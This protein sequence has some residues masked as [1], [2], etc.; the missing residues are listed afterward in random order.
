MIG[1]RPPLAELL[2]WCVDSNFP[3]G[4]PEALAQILGVHFESTVLSF[5]VEDWVLPH[6]AC[7][8]SL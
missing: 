3:C 6:F 4:V 8:P 2:A 1:D 7:G 5:G